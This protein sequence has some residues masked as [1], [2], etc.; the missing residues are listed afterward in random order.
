MLNDEGIILAG[1]ERFSAQIKRSSGIH[2]RRNSLT[3]NEMGAVAQSEAE[4]ASER[5]G[6][7]SL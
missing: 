5:W 2:Q 6:W 1:L 7:L 4:K 3:D